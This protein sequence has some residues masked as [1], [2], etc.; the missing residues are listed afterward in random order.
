LISILGFA[1]AGSIVFWKAHS[2]SPPE[3]APAMQCPAT[4]SYVA[5]GGLL[6]LLAAHTIFAGQVHS[7]TSTI[8]AQ[9]FNPQPYISIVLDTP[10]KLSTP[11]EDH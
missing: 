1:R 5:V 10:G 3:D 11:L 8:A 9:L 4:L 7:Y 2:I 6:S